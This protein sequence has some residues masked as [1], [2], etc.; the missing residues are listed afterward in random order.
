MTVSRAGTATTGAHGISQDCRHR[1]Q[2]APTAPGHQLSG[3]V[4]QTIELLALLFLGMALVRTFAAEAYV[5]PT[6]SM[7]PTLL[8]LHRELACPSCGFTFV[9]GLDDEG[10]TP[11]PICPNCG[12]NGLDNASALECGGDRVLVEKLLYELRHPQRWE[13]AVFHFPGEPS[14]AYVKRIVGLPGESIRIADGD[15]I[16]DGRIARKSWSEIQAMRILVH[17]SRFQ[18]PGSTPF[19]RWQSACG[20]DS[21]LTPS[22]WSRH[23]G[24]LTHSAQSDAGSAR[25]DW[26]VYDHQDP[27][28]R[29]PG[30]VSDFYG[31]NGGEQRDYS[32]VNDL[33]LE[34]RMQVS[35][36]LKEIALALQSG[37]D[38]FVLRIPVAS[39]GSIELFR[40]Q[41]QVPL[42]NAQ[43]PFMDR[44]FDRRTVV[45]EAAAFDCS[46]QVT[47]DG[48][49]LFD[50][51][52]YNAD[53]RGSSEEKCRSIDGS[54]R[55]NPGTSPT[56]S[57]RPIA[58]GVVGDRAQISELKIFRDVYYTRAL[59]NTP[60]HARGMFETVR[61]G[62]DDYF[63]LG[64]NSPVSNDS[65]FWS[66]GPVVKRSMFVGRPILVHIPGQVVSLQ[67]FGRSVCWV[68]DPR[69]IRYIR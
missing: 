41:R 51:F 6:G 65:R 26:L 55:E 50:R 1:Y 61:L 35:N 47:I 32:E 34:A 46:L 64:D 39:Q 5:V 56:S 45:V 30:P 7:A 68:P 60:Q 21:R 13:V 11:Q 67:V 59:T 42:S 24:Q 25:C 18:P 17:D 38:Q 23:N 8:G 33:A 22:G 63:V 40:N 58:L 3:F 54:G 37:A 31:Y 69:R 49:A 28:R 62:P 29:G 57:E 53:P 44:R 43:N 2:T 48:R 14:Q 52:D 9:I 19:A 16:V 10:Q 20:H 15:V 66:E 27:V 12:R 36:S 4:R